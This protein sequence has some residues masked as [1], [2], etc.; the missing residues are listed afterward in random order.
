MGIS[1]FAQGEVPPK[2]PDEPDG[3]PEG[4]RALYCASISSYVDETHIQ[5]FS[6]MIA[7]SPFEVRLRLRRRFGSLLESEAKVTLGF[8]CSEPLACALVSDAMADIL[9]IAAED[10]NSAFADG[11]D[12]Q[13]EQRFLA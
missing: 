7:R 1:D 9:T 10:P 3:W 13:V 12:F 6:A 4:E 2:A 8:D 5:V 11:L